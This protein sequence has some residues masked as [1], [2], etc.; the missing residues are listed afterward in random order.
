MDVASSPEHHDTLPFPFETDYE[1]WLESRN[2]KSQHQDF[3]DLGWQ[4]EYFLYY[5]SGQIAKL[6]RFLKFKPDAK[7]HLTRKVRFNLLLM[8]LKEKLGMKAGF[9]LL[10]LFGIGMILESNGISIGIPRGLLVTLA[11]C[12]VGFYLISGIMKRL[13]VSFYPCMV[14]KRSHLFADCHKCTGNGVFEGMTCRTCNGIGMF[15]YFGD[16][17]FAFTDEGLPRL[18]EREYPSE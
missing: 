5:A 6:R 17:A 13:P 14:G 9:S 15:V 16:P 8:D 18:N 11:V 10:M 7:V 4:I 12:L 3:D 2:G 1:N